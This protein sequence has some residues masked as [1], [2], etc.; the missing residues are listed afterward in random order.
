VTNEDSNTSYSIAKAKLIADQ[1]ARLAT[2]HPHQLAGELSN[3]DFW[4][5]EAAAAVAVINEY[6]TRFRRLR[7]SQVAWVRARDLN[8]PLY[9]PICRGRCELEAHAPAAPRRIPSEELAIARNHVKLSASRLLIRLHRGGLINETDLRRHAE[10]LQIR[11][12]P[13]DLWERH[14]EISETTPLR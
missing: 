9:C 13:E 8:I 14:D 4:M 1:L 6:P 11:I 7:D 2:Q 3:L 10:S 5:A 12:E